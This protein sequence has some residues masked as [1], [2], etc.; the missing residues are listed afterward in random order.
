MLVCTLGDLALDVIVRL[1]GPI[2]VGGDTSASTRLTPGGQAANV[3]AWVAE[4]GA[5]ARFVGKRGADD[6]GLVASRGLASYGVEIVGPAEGEGAV[7]C[8]L[9]DQNGERSMLSD[10]GASTEF[11]PDELDPVWL[12]GCDH[13]F[14]SGYA[15]LAE[16]IRDATL[17]AVGLARGHGG[18]ISVDLS[19]WSAI[20]QHGAESFRA[21][22]DQLAPDVV[23][24]NEDEERILGGRLEHPAWI[25]KRGSG[26]CSIRRRRT[27][28]AA[29]RGRNRLDRR[30]RR[31]RGGLH[32]GRPRARAR[33]RGPVRHPT[34]VDAVTSTIGQLKIAAM[35]QVEAE[36]IAGLTYDG[37]YAFYNW[38]ADENDLAE[39]LD[40]ELRGDRYFS[41]HESS[42]E[43]IGFFSFR[44]EGDAVVIGL[45]LRPDLTG[46]GLGLGYVEDGLAFARQR[47]APLRFRLSVA[48]FNARAISVYERAGFVTTRSFVHETNGGSHAFVEMERPA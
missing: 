13:L 2:A 7:I 37:P 6:A 35:S 22:L 21:L 42:G 1:D 3:A 40:S 31:A 9:V 43:L 44:H 23:F 29:Y 33:G 4:L 18:R 36:T 27:G 25:L 26:G 8:S 30:G 34:R 46:R 16:P 11:R 10:R 45:G 14:V 48:K 12:E 17:A 28:G 39:L 32:R 47:Y 24:A 5:P 38:S 15:L 20:E 19:S 41:A